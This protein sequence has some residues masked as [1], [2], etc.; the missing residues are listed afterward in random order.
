MTPERWQQVNELF[1]AAVELE[2]AQR[3][4]FLNQNCSSDGL[5][6]SEV[7]SLFA[8]DRRGWNLIE[9]PAVEVAA[10]L[11]ANE[12]PQL[13]RGQ[14]FSHYEILSLIGR[15]GMGEVYLATDKL[16]NRR[17][18]L[19]LLP[20]DYT[21]DK[22]RLRRFQKE[23]HAA[24]ALN[25]PNILT[26][27]ELR[28]VEGRQFIATE[29]VDGETLRQRLKRAPLPLSEILEIAIQ[30]ASALS[31]AHRVGIVHRDI[32]PE[33]VM[34]RPDGY[35]KVLDFGLAKLTEQVERTPNARSENEFDISS[36]L[37]MGTVKYMSPEQTRGSSVDARSDMF[38]F[39][40]VFYEMIAGRTPF[41]GE[42][43]G[44]LVTAILKE[45]PAPLSQFSPGALK[46]L[47]HIVSRT[48]RKDRNERYPDIEDLLFDLK[49]LQ[50]NLTIASRLKRSRTLAYESEPVAQSDRPSEVQTADERAVSTAHLIPQHT[51]SSADYLVTQFRRH[52][53]WAGAAVVILCL[54][55][56]G[57]GYLS[58]KSV[59]PQ[60][61]A[62]SN[63]FELS[64]LT[65]SG[66]VANAAIS[67][68]GRYVAYFNGV[69]VWTRQVATNS[70]V[71][72]IPGGTGSYWGLTFSPDGNYLYYFA[73]LTT[74]REPP[75]LYRIPALGGVSTKLIPNTIN[76][77]GNDRVTFSPDGTRLAFVREYASGETALTVANVDGTDER[78]LA[79][80]QGSSHFGSAAWSPD[81]NRIV[82][83][84]GYQENKTNHSEL[85]EI[86]IEDGVEKPITTQEWYYI[87][88]IAWVRDG[89]ALLI[90]ASDRSG[91]PGQVWK[92]DYPSGTAHRVSTDLNSYSGLSLTADSST[93]VTV[94]G[95]MSMNIWTQAKGDLTQAKQITSGAA[96]RDGM[97]GIGWTLDGRIVYES[98]ASGRPDIW[99][100]N[101]DGSSATQLSRDLGTD[102]NGLSVSPDGRYVVFVSNRGGKNNIWRVDIDGANPKQ[103]TNGSGE[104]NPV[105]S[106]DSQW[107]AYNSWDPGGPIP[108]KVPVD[109]GVP[110]QLTG[111]YA[112]VAPHPRAALGI[113]P[114]GTLL[115]FYIP[116]DDQTKVSRI[117]VA[118]IDGED[119][120]KVFD[121]PS[122]V[123]AP[124]RT[125]WA[126]D[127]EALTYIDNRGGVSNIW[128]QPLDGSPR[129]QL[130]DFKADS[131]FNFAWS[132]DGKQ[133]AIVRAINSNDVVMM[134]NFS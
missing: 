87:G 129:Q 96:A 94:R 44:E 2:P 30:I 132:R 11:L 41:A 24:S 86:G 38:S 14:T 134:K 37:V 81:G 131:I 72:I 104:L 91:E 4:A 120:I 27:Y 130:T 101:A 22:G 74:D 34:L 7:E 77:N 92:V 97:A 78:K 18:A 102:R 58:Y 84:G 49:S 55:I 111:P 114:D 124:Q 125:R 31:A 103:L 16:L 56:L 52:K 10:P 61:T 121:L 33:N 46:E 79:T 127:G 95:Q 106:P 99:I 15:G 32:K 118:S 8:S 107:V 119:T 126:P 71:E 48:L 9:R 39:G 70:Q 59:S 5:L 53:R 73:N 57:V 109:G 89:S 128:S 19:K 80:R 115:A 66:N 65:T 21:K 45:E 108:W 54:S 60:R 3:A 29:F 98:N 43:T 117:G 12:E 113:S 51:V 42:T 67:R 63:R 112:N 20:A 47:Q 17:T 26:I 62:S 40:V 93:L 64:G 100:M 85:V 25:H 28:E 90:T 110:I 6:R 23:A 1:M 68:D 83:R 35:V 75:A 116:P 88:D 105:F 76:S 122:G 82:C 123:I 50:E 36:D 69:G 13:T 133:L